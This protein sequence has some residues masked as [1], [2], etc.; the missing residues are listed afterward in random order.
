MIDSSRIPKIPSFS[1][2]ALIAQVKDGSF[3]VL[4]RCG[5]VAGDPYLTGR[6]PEMRAAFPPV[7]RVVS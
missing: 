2:P 4:A 3:Q 5:Q 7:L 6:R 1:L